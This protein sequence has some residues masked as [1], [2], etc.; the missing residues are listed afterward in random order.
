MRVTFPHTRLRSSTTDP[1]RPIY[2]GEACLIDQN[3][4]K[5]LLRL[6][7]TLEYNEISSI[8]LQLKY[9][10]HLNTANYEKHGK[11]SCPDC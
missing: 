10:K 1:A 11:P 4:S 8:H 5:C 6:L 2:F 7:N 3:H 9:K